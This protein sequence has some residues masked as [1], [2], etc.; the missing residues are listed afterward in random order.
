M[1][2]KPI[3]NSIF[4]ESAQVAVSIMPGRQVGALNEELLMLLLTS[5]LEIEQERIAGMTLVMR[6][7]HWIINLIKN[8]YLKV[9]PL[10]KFNKGFRLQTL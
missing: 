6:L 7:F 3:K 5:A 4:V 2:L 8:S 9:V 1:K 10:I